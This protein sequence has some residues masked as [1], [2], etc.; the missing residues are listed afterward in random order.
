MTDVDL[1]EL[2]RDTRDREPLL[3]RVQAIGS[4]LAQ[5]LAASRSDDDGD[6]PSAPVDREIVATAL[7]RLLALAVDIEAG[8][9]T[10]ET[11]DA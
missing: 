5:E 4:P 10:A 7:R 9:Y 1:T 3:A 11:G 2:D 8:L 6:E